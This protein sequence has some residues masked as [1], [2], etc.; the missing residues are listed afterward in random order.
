MI[1][2]IPQE[3]NG[4]TVLGELAQ[5]AQY[6]T[7][8]IANSMLQLGR[9]LSEAK[10]LVPHGEWEGWILE[11]TGFS[12]R[13]A[14]MYMQAY[15]RFG[16]NEAAARI[17]ER[18]K[19]IKLLSLPAGTEEKFLEDNDVAAMS[20]REVEEAVRQVRAEMQVQIDAERE[21]RR[22]AEKKACGDWGG[23]PL[24]EEVQKRLD[25]HSRVM[26]EKDDEIIR[27]AKMGR[28]A[29]EEANRLRQENATL[30]REV[31]EQE[32]MLEESQEGYNRLQADLLNM[33]SM[34]AK[35]DAER[36]PSEALT[37]DVFTGA[38]QQFL[39][40]CARMPQMSKRFAVMP[41][42]EKNDWDELLLVIEKWAADA[43]IALNTMDAEGV[44]L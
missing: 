18:G 34:V 25:D 2:M 40:V 3:N 8:N 6:Y 14:Q 41:L 23:I 21:M 11:N 4:L 33:Q 27:V 15:H 5:E 9:V 28:E 37:F 44:I 36:I 43:R 20:T 12:V 10:P 16:S 38:V 32:A 1:E 7:R 35:G 19:I 22:Q 30:Q 17:G 26:K 29:L 24:P 13:Y 39:C 42:A 31:A